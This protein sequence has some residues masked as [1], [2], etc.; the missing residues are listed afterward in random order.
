MNRMIVFLA[1]SVVTLMA[2]PIVLSHHE[3]AEIM[4]LAW[5][6]AAGNAAPQTGLFGAHCAACPA[7]IFG[8]VAMLAAW[9][10][11]LRASARKH[12]PNG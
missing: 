8:L 6:S 2:F 10:L 5:C 9:V 1:G 12:V 7:L 3:Q 4:A 11:P